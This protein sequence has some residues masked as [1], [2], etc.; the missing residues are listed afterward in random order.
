MPF[1]LPERE[2]ELAELIADYDASNSDRYR[3]LFSD[4][5]R[6][7]F[8]DTYTEYYSDLAGGL[9]GITENTPISYDVWV[10]V[11][12]QSA[13]LVTKAEA[14]A[15]LHEKYP[16]YDW[17]G[18]QWASD[19][20]DLSK[21]KDVIDKLSK[22][23]EDPDAQA[24]PTQI[25]R[26]GQGVSGDGLFSGGVGGGGSS[27]T[28]I[29]VDE[30]PSEYD[31][32][33]MQS[34]L[35][36]VAEQAALGLSQVGNGQINFRPN[37]I[38]GGAVIPGTLTPDKFNQTSV[39]KFA[40]ETPGEAQTVTLEVA[41]S[42]LVDRYAPA[43]SIEAGHTG[44]NRVYEVRSVFLPR[45]A[46]LRPGP[47]RYRVVTKGLKMGLM[48]IRSEGGNIPNVIGE[49]AHLTYGCVIRNIPSFIGLDKIPTSMEAVSVGYPAGQVFK[50]DDS[51]LYS[52]TFEDEFVA[53]AFGTNAPRMYAPF[54]EPGPPNVIV[55]TQAYADTIEG[56]SFQVPTG[57][58]G[59]EVFAQV[60]GQQTSSGDYLTGRG[61]GVAASTPPG[62]PVEPPFPIQLTYSISATYGGTTFQGVTET[63]L[64]TVGS[65]PL[66]PNTSAG[67]VRGAPMILDDCAKI[68]ATGT[69]FSLVIQLF[70][71]YQILVH[72]NGVGVSLLGATTSSNSV[73]GHLNNW[74]RSGIEIIESGRRKVAIDII[75]A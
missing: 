72:D 39:A 12:A 54:N 63:T 69:H 46:K 52:E 22:P 45:G 42:Q 47:I 6:G 38:D 75:V 14:V 55:P 49:V 35:N 23:S 20:A 3:Q 73:T 50:F 15:S 51:Y 7:T 34:V 31:P 13:G 59:R 56:M 37:T 62:L 11:H 18:G 66:P 29:Y 74:G 1:L 4:T 41:K 2:Q 61:L 36:G 40:R 24:F 26:A 27:E 65:T 67:W 28:S 60:N 30:V 9:N 58:T 53:D 70:P 43:D 32:T 33:E 21:V 48:S 10:L 44:P 57:R 19:T 71:S 25:L 17:A 68:A 8:V 64:E 5:F 16:N